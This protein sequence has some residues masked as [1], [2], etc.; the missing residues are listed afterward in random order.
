[1]KPTT[2][3]VIDMLPVS[4]KNPEEVVATL[5]KNFYANKTRSL[6]FRKTQLKNLIR[7]FEDNQEEL[8]EALYK[9]LRKP[10]MESVLCEI[11]FTLN[12]VKNLLWNLDEYAMPEYPEK[13]LVN[14]LDG[15]EI[16]K[17]PYGVVLIIGSWNYPLNIALN[18]MAGE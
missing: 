7:F 16:H 1:M 9:D 2:E 6:K 10:K 13:G 4:M 12:E 11:Q 8:C 18:P 14:M 15:V 5:R 3:A 17:D